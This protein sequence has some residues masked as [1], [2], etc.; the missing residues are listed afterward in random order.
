[1]EK[2]AF[3]AQYWPNIWYNIILRN[4]VESILGYWLVIGKPRVMLTARK[5]ATKRRRV[6]NES[7]P[8]AV[9]YM[10]LSLRSFSV[11]MD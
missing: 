2:S 11:W 6:G 3:Y 1:V 5:A 10:R 7:D 8:K 9:V 4:R